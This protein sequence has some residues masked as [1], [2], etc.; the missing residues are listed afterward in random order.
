MRPR[1]LAAWLGLAGVLAGW[2][3]LSAALEVLAL[4]AQPDHHRDMPLGEVFLAVV[5]VNRQRRA[6]KPAHGG[7][8]LRPQAPKLIEEVFCSIPRKLTCTE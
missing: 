8:G 1:L 2:P 3:T 5:C 6:G 7:S 4:A